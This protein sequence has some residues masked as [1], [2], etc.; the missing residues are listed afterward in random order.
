VFDEQGGSIGRG[1]GNDWILDD[2]DSV[3][4]SRHA[5]VRANKSGF[6]IVDVST[7]GTGLNSPE[8]LVP[9]GH[10][11]PLS[12]GDRLFLG[13]F[14]ILV[15]VIPQVEPQIE[16][17]IEPVTSES[18]AKQGTDAE[19]IE[20]T[21]ATGEL[22]ADVPAPVSAAPA[23]SDQP[24]MSPIDDATPPLES[25][26]GSS[27]PASEPVVDLGPVAAA[28]RVAQSEFTADIDAVVARDILHLVTRGVIDA[29]ATRAAIKGQFRMSL[30]YVR[31][32]ENNPLK[33]ADSAADA[34]NAMLVDRNP[35]YLGPTESFSQA[36]DDLQRHQI[37][38]SEGM[39]A[40]YV[41]VLQRFDPQ[42]IEIDCDKEGA[43]RRIFSRFTPWRYWNYYR[44]LYARLTR[45]FDATYF[46]LFGEEFV[47]AYDEKIRRLEDDHSQQNR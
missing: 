44:A 6:L 9:H 11:V 20:E 29:L 23:M 3:L 43:R 30:T 32:Q 42:R 21:P 45:D 25:P 4:S 34:L 35:G 28:P 8:S 24:S 2:P 5:I 41:A 27:V 14:E 1:E 17:Q 22:P 10:G 13:D 16:P 19:S 46:E 47:R 7:N 38:M 12:E 18:T 26:P 40:A 31:P 15:Q 39:R 36:F 33:F 37:A